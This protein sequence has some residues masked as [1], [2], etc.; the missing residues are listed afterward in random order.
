MKH[1]VAPERVGNFDRGQVVFGG[2]A[3]SVGRRICRLT[4]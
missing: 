2:T 4:G 3:G 1:V